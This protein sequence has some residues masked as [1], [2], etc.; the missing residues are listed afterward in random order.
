MSTRIEAGTRRLTA[1]ADRAW[2]R[3]LATGASPAVLP[4]RLLYG[5]IFFAHGA[6]KLFGAFGGGGPTGTA[7]GFE[8]M[9]FQ[10]GILWAVVA[11]LVELV[12]GLLLIVG[13][14]SRLVAALLAVQML[15]AI[16]AVHWPHG[17]FAPQGIEYPL[18]LVAGLLAVLVYGGGRWS[19]DRTITA[20]TSPPAA[21]PR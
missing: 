6:Q 2:R 15:V 13:L 21:A 3:V 20:A 14:L 11:G 9:G 19:A 8:Q 7:Q 10:P 5:V 1:A 18:A 16:F 17:F 4:V 12:G